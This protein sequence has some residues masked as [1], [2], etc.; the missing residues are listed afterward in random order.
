MPGCSRRERQHARGG[1]S[2][3]EVLSGSGVPG[4]DELRRTSIPYQWLAARGPRRPG[5]V[6][7]GV[8]AHVQ[9]SVGLRLG[10]AEMTDTSGQGGRRVQRF[11]AFFDRPGKARD[12][13][14]VELLPLSDA[15]QYAVNGP[16]AVDTVY[17]NLPSSDTRLVAFADYD[18]QVQQDKL[19]E[20]LRIVNT[21]GAS[22][23]V[24]QA[25]RG[26]SRSVRAGARAPGGHA[27]VGRRHDDRSDVKF[28]QRGTGGQP[29]DPRPLLY[30]DEPGFEAACLNV[31][32][33]GG[34]YV[35]IEIQRQSQFS[36]RGDLAMSLQ[37]AGFKLGASSEKS[38]STEL[39]IEAHFGANA[40]PI[41]E[42]AAQG[43]AQRAQERGDGWG[44]TP[45]VP[46][47][48]P[49]EAAAKGRVKPSR[50][51]R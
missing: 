19:N 26:S 42:T 20:A 5:R 46:P 30:P 24:A 25:V 39:V 11:V 40:D 21:L 29:A 23:V 31:L 51:T 8:R 44:A 36:V 49:R 12:S 17:V 6:K 34:S 1:A 45:A 15:S 13:C 18:E 48:P 4:P 38:R 50:W 35:K 41:P 9:S 32:N 43:S 16:V 2:Q 28:E 14:G 10:G 33:N 37:K 22:Y 47:G 27:S 3:S 7:L